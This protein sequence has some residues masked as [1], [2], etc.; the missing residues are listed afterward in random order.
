MQEV[1]DRQR[2]LVSVLTRRAEKTQREFRHILS[3]ATNS[4]QNA[5]T[6]YFFEGVG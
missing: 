3:T 2:H 6:Y 5:N 4:I 1:E